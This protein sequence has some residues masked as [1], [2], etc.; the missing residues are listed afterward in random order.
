[1][2][3]ENNCKAYY[4]EKPQKV[5]YANNYVSLLKSPNFDAVKIKRFTV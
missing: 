5:N 1:M 4:I 2:I 3:I